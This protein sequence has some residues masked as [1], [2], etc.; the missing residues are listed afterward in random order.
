MKRDCLDIKDESA[1]GFSCMVLI[2]QSH[3]PPVKKIF[4]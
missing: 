1:V 2:S 3:F 4:S